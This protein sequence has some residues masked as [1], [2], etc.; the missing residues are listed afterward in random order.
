[1]QYR[2]KFRSSKITQEEIDAIFKSECIDLAQFQIHLWKFGAN[3]YACKNLLKV[4]KGAFEKSKIDKVL[5][6]VTISFRIT[7]AKG[8]I[9]KYTG[10][11]LVDYPK[12]T[13]V[14]TW[15]SS[16]APKR[17][18][19][20]INQVRQI[21]K[22][23]RSGCNSMETGLISA[24]SNENLDELISKINFLSVQR[25]IGKPRISKAN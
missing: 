25:V 23:S 10:K 13:S 18:N 14:I 19:L 9:G 5:N 17:K 7:F 3:A 24:F 6:K 1:M 8:A 20:S 15:P 16:A 4:L 22:S 11:C 21:L 2:F 12:D